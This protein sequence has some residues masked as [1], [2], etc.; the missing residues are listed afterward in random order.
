MGC[1]WWPGPST[2]KSPAHPLDVESS[3]DV[4]EVEVREFRRL[5][6]LDVEVEEF[7]PTNSTCSIVAEPQ[8]TRL[9]LAT[10]TATSSLQESGCLRY[11]TNDPCLD[12]EVA[13]LVGPPDTSPCG[14]VV[15]KLSSPSQ[16]G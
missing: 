5:T 16:T 13:K 7:V 1:C 4:A 11:G 8:A 3:E 6:L 14:C 10:W 12:R 15:P 2:N 9:L